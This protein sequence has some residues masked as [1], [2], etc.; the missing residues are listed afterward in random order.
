MM[1]LIKQQEEAEESGAKGPCIQSNM[2]K[3]IF[4]PIA[5]QMVIFY[6]DFYKKFQDCHHMHLMPDEKTP[7]FWKIVRDAS[8]KN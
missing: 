5:I 4:L 8:F 7:A 6:P 1:S 2:C 3:G